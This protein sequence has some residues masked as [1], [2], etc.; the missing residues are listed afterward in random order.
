MGPPNFPIGQDVQLALPRA[1]EYVPWGQ[2]AHCPLE[3]ELENCPSKQAL[4]LL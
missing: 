3:E 4:Q 1:L 2:G